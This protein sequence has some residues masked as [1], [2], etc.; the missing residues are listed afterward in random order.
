MGTSQAAIAR[1]EATESDPRLSTVERYANAIQDALRAR[2][3]DAPKTY[4]LEAIEQFS[5]AAF[6]NAAALGQDGHTLL[7][8]G[9]IARAYA[10]AELAAEELGKC[11]ILIRV[12]T[13]IALGNPVDWPDLKRRL[14]DHG[15]KIRTLTMF[16][17]ALTDQT[18]A[19]ASHDVEALVRDGAGRRRAHG[20]ASEALLLRERAFYVEL[21]AAGLSTPDAAIKRQDAEMMLQAITG[22]ISKMRAVGLPPPRGQYKR[23]ARDP[24]FRKKA[25][26]LR[27]S[28]NRL[29]GLI[30]FE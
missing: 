24:Q 12:G 18:A 30:P 19:Y 28:L 2:G 11:L 10:L 17:W 8:A 25:V 4:S 5:A 20:E 15:A 14:N 16:D 6:S 7:V 21:G 13:D 9:R 23:N 27:K 26:G 3:A 1:V 29:P 22:T